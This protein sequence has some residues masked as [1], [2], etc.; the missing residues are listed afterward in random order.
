MPVDLSLSLTCSTLSKP[1]SCPLERKSKA[2]DLPHLHYAFGISSV[3][4]FHSSKALSISSPSA[5]N[6]NT[7]ANTHNTTLFKEER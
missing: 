7:I 3:C 4:S 1:I 6:A 5:K 2:L